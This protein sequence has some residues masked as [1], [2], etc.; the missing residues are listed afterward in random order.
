ML[1]QLYLFCGIGYFAQRGRLR[2]FGQLALDLFGGFHA[3]LVQLFGAGN[4]VA[5]AVVEL[6]VGGLVAVLRLLDVFAHALQRG[7]EAD[8]FVV[9][10]AALFGNGQCVL[11]LLLV[12]PDVGHGAQGGQKRAGAY[13]H[14]AF[15]EAFLEELVV[16]LQR[17]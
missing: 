2:L 1:T 7:D 16:V 15:V 12:A 5:A 4:E 3:E 9:K 14:D 11:V 10:P 8:E 6:F 13:Q 17:Q